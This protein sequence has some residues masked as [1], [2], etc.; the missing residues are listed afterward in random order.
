MDEQQYPKNQPAT[1]L[2]ILLDTMRIHMA[3][4]SHPQ[5]YITPRE[6]LDR[7][8]YPKNRKNT[9][10]F[11]NLGQEWSRPAKEWE[12]ILQQRDDLIGDHMA[13]NF[14]GYIWWDKEKSLFAE[15]VWQQREPREVVTAPTL[16]ELI[17]AVN[18]KYGWR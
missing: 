9:I 6:V 8:Q 18:D 15:E 16:Y 2:E 12:E 11:R 3:A 5:E 14:K 7:S 17:T 13:W 1:E 4:K 10:I